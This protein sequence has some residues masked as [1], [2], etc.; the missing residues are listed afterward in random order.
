MKIVASIEAR[1]NSSRLP[2]KVLTNIYGR[3]TLYRIVERL[4]ASRSVDD[5]VVATTIDISD[6]ILEDW[7]NK[8]NVAC[9]RGS[10][11]DVLQRVVKAHEMMGTDLI[12]EITGDDPLTDPEVVDLGVETFLAHDVDLVTNCGAY[13]SWPMGVHVQVFSL[14]TLKKVEETVKDRAVREH[15]SLY[16]YENPDIYKIINLI[17]PRRWQKPDY[18]LQLDYEEDLIFLDEVFKKLEPIYGSVFGIEE[19]MRL[20][21]S[22]QNLL[23]INKHCIEKPPR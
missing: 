8:N 17:A 10:E 11:E 22:N 20:L 2:G 23:K 21:Q 7:C 15:V 16:F 9:Y 4:K 12:V 19:V 13:K 1:M 14:E 3:E 18:R 6:D 5:I